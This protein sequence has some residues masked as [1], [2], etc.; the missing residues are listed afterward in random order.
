WT[1]AD[2]ARRARLWRYAFSQ[3]P[4]RGGLLA[5]DSSGRADAVEA[6]ETRAAGIRGVLA[7]HPPGTARTSWYVGHQA[8]SPDG[9]SSLWRQDSAGAKAARCGSDATHHCWAQGVGPLSYWQ[10][11]GEVWSLS[12]RML[13]SVPLSSIDSSLG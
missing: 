2:P 3:D 4:A 5:T 10:E 9:R 13:F 7:Y 8:D 11:T 6:Y 1:P 12:D